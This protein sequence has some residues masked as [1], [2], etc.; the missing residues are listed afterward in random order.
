MMTKRPFMTNAENSIAKEQKKETHAERQSRIKSEAVAFAFSG[1]T[2]NELRRR[3]AAEPTT[4]LTQNFKDLER[5]QK[6]TPKQKDGKNSKERERYQ[7][8]TCKQ[9]DANNS[10]RQKLTRKQ[11]NA[12]NSKERERYQ[13]NKEKMT[14]LKTKDAST[15]LRNKTQCEH[16]ICEGRRNRGTC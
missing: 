9:K 1:V 16:F 11:K 3:T 14:A 7:K 13:K 2:A 6:L 5:Y 10:K 15:A 12:K 4:K 8:S